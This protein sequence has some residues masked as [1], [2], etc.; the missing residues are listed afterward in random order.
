[1]EIDH[2]GVTKDRTESTLS[3]IVF[4]LTRPDDSTQWK[5]LMPETKLTHLQQAEVRMLGNLW[6][7]TSESLYPKESL[8]LGQEWQADPKAFGAIFSPRLKVDDGKVTCRLD[9]ITVLIK[10]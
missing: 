1:M 10:R 8:E 3:G 6:D 4:D 2:G 5:I 7:E 9:E